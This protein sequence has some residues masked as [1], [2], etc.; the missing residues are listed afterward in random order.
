ME[1]HFRDPPAEPAPSKTTRP[2]T[3]VS[4]AD[5]AI[6][7][8]QEVMGVNR[9]T[10]EFAYMLVDAHLAASKEQSS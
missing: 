2:D 5:R 4:A 7:L 9:S 6:T 1:N 10:A 8:Y 3:A